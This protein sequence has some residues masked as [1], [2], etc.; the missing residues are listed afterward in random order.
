MKNFSFLPSFLPDIIQGKKTQTRRPVQ[1]EAV[2][3]IILDSVNTDQML[4]NF[5]DRKKGVFKQIQAKY[6][7][8]EIVE[9][10]DADI[11]TKILEVDV[12][13]LGDISEEDIKAEG[14]GLREDHDGSLK[15]PQDSFIETWT[16]IYGICGYSKHRWVWVYKFEYV[17]K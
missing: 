9:V 4:F 5:Y 15:S 1:I 10:H 6:L 3:H 16:D 17:T 8:G 7:P 2:S 11:Q 13:R 12:E 14:I